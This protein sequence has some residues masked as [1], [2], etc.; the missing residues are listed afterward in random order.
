MEESK[1]KLI[2]AFPRASRWTLQLDITDHTGSKSIAA[3]DGG[4]E[5]MGV[6]CASSRSMRGADAPVTR[7]LYSLVGSCREN[8]ALFRTGLCAERTGGKRISRV[9]RRPLFFPS[10]P[11][12]PFPPS[13]VYY[14]WPHLSCDGYHDHTFALLCP[15]PFPL[16]PPPSADELIRHLGTTD[17]GTLKPYVEHQIQ[18][19]RMLFRLQVRAER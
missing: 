17:V 14:T 7:V 11:H 19:Q 2:N 1:K 10:S 9:L 3:F 12:L 16:P 18:H 4:K 13:A 8:R 6:R 5:V 15:L